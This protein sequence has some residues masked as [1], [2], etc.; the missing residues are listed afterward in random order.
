MARKQYIL[1]G[2]GNWQSMFGRALIAIT[3]VS[4]SGRK[5]TLRSLDVEVHT[6]AGA[7]APAQ[8]AKA[9]LYKA[10]SISGGENMSVRVGKMDSTATLPATVVVSKNG[11]IDA[12]TTPLRTVTATRFGAGAGTQNTLNTHRAIGKF[13]GLYSSPKRGSESIVEP[14]FRSEEHTS[15]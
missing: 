6:I 7:G 13:S 14:I 5:L 2:E 10:A 11:M 12:Y 8:A 3:N 15:E 9:I 1:R 4:G